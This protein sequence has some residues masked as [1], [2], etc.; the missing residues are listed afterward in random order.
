MISPSLVTG[1]FC[2]LST[3][4]AFVH[5]NEDQFHATKDYIGNTMWIFGTPGVF[6]Y[7]PDGKELI[8]S[9]DGD[10]ICK[11]EPTTESTSRYNSAC[12]Y[13][14]VVSDGKKFVWTALRRDTPKIDVFD[15]NSGA[16]VGSF[17]TC[18]SPSRL[19]YHALRDEIWVRCTEVDANHTVP[20]NLDVFSAS[21][22]SGDI[23]TDILLKERALEEGLSSNGHTIIH[24]TLGDIG[25][26]TDSELS[27]LFKLDLSTKAIVDKIEMNPPSHGLNDASYSPVNQHIYV[28]SEVCCT[29]GFEDSDLG[30]DCGRYEPYDVSPT[31]GKFAGKNDVQG[32]CGRGCEAKPGIDTIGVYEFDTATDTVVATHVMKEGFSGDPLPSPDGKYIVL[33]ARNGG[34]TIR[35]IEAGEPGQPSTNIFD[36][37]LDFNRTGY[38]DKSVALDFA[39]VTTPDDRTLVIFPSGTE[40]KIGIVDITNGKPEKIS[41]VTFNDEPFI[42]GRAPHGRYRRVEWAIGTNYV[43]V[44]DSSLDE[45][46]VIDFVNEEVV[47]VLT[48]TDVSKM[49]SVQNYEYQRQFEMQKQLVMDMTQ[50]GGSSS[51]MYAATSDGGDTELKSSPITIAAIVLGAVAIVVGLLN[52]MKMNNISNE[53]EA[54]RK[55][56]KEPMSVVGGSQMDGDSIVVPSVN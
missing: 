42:A 12:R 13:Y 9:I 28:R 31:T 50:G 15:I 49:I 1:I 23:Q 45:V 17:K 22:P 19:E 51:T 20:S 8:N 34:K 35:I 54:L 4:S 38:E 6:I 32:T 44:T 11:Q 52:Y 25:Y 56:E 27:T 47:T 7:S 55:K 43:W 10:R 18:A 46:Y 5:T 3:A 2:L 30:E 16:L 24:N 29:C 40:H 14:D 41:Y 39:F 53:F 48:D 37:E 26:L 21:S 33:L 36:V